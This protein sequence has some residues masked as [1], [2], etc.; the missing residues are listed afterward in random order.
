MKLRKV[1]RI[2]SRVCKRIGTEEAPTTQVEGRMG[3]CPVGNGCHVA[4]DRIWRGARCGWMS[5]PAAP[6]KGVRSS[7]TADVVCRSF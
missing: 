6:V 1:K 2:R 7:V 5:G 3:F 4:G